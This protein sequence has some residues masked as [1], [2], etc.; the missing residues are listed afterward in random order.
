MRYKAPRR[1]RVHEEVRTADPFVRVDVLIP[2]QMYLDMQ[3]ISKLGVQRPISRMIGYA[4]YNEFEVERPFTFDMTLPELDF[5]PG[6]FKYEA[7]VLHGFLAK[8]PS[9]CGLDNLVLLKGELGLTKTQVL[10]AYMELKH[11]DR[12]E[13][14]HP[15]GQFFNYPPDYMYVRVKDVHRSTMIKNRF[16]SFEG[17]YVPRNKGET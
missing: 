5:V 16:R 10:L 3:A 12:I 6:K 1:P 8:L 2:R 15:G 13:E 14:Y 7:D 17:K 11:Q 9:G 4:I